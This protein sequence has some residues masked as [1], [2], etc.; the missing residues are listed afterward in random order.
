MGVPIK[1]TI[2]HLS[3]LGIMRRLFEF[4]KRIDHSKRILVIHIPKT[5]GTSLRQMLEREYGARHIYPG[6]FYLKS[7][8]GGY[9][10]GSQMLKDYPGLPPHKVLI[11]HFTAAMADMIPT[12]YQTAT[13]LREPIQRSLSMLSHFS[14]KLHVPVAALLENEQF[15]TD[16]IADF[17]TRMMGADGVCDPHEVG[18]VDDDALAR[19]LGRL[20]S[21]DFVGIT[22][23]FT[24]SCRRF[25]RLFKTRISKSIQ[26]RNV[27]RPEGTE[28]TEHIPKIEPLVKRDKILYDSALARFNA[29]KA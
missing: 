24:E 22:E 17:Q 6:R 28:L 23:Q 3:Q 13:F 5:A 16:G 15:M 11:G 10:L 26:R 1:T 9:P 20:E 25:D 18:T 27:L 4:F 12:P 29:Y 2:N 8:G 19:A 7:L 21:L 14:H